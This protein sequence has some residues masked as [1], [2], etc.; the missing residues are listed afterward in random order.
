MDEKGMN[1]IIS[2]MKVILELQKKNKIKPQGFNDRIGV[3]KDIYQRNKK[4]K[5]FINTLN[6]AVTSDMEQLFELIIQE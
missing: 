4:D 1:K 6:K 3:A 5:E 2:V